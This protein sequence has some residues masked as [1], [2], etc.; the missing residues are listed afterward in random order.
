M[1]YLSIYCTIL[2]L[3]LLIPTFLHLSDADEQSRDSDNVD[4]GHGREVDVKQ[5]LK[6]EK[7]RQPASRVKLKVW[8]WYT[9]R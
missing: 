2:E 1:S 6:N 5:N 8:N 9:F 7:S 4:D 3:L